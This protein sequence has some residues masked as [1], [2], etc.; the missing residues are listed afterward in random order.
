MVS[1]LFGHRGCHSFLLHMLHTVLVL[2]SG[3]KILICTK[4]ENRKIC[5]LPSSFLVSIEIKI[6]RNEFY[7]ISLYAFLS[8]QREITLLLA[9]LNTMSTPN[10]R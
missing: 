4:V 9:Q 3:N 10:T 7:L 5:V 1:P 2:G 8:L 6:R